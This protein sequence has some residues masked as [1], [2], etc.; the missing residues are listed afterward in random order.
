MLICFLVTST[1]GTVL[2]NAGMVASAIS[3]IVKRLLG[4]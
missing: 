3:A 1:S 4:D 2:A